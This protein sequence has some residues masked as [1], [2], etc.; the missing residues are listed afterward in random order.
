MITGESVR[1]VSV[2]DEKR[3]RR[4]DMM[5]RDAFIVGKQHVA[6]ALGLKAPRE[7]EK[8]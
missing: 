3:E 5:R 4:E 7:E 2:A 8:K 1:R 6:F